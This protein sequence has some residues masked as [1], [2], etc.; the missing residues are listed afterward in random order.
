MPSTPNRSAP[1][2]YPWQEEVAQNGLPGLLDVPTGLGKTEGIVLGSA[3]R[4]RY[5]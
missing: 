3:T 4:G 2:P 5:R 1:K